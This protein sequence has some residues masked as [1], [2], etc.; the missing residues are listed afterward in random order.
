MA[1]EEKAT[2][3]DNRADAW[4][5]F[6]PIETLFFKLDVGYDYRNV[7]RYGYYRENT[8]ATSFDTSDDMMKQHLQNLRARLT[9]GTLDPSSPVDVRIGLGVES[10][11]DRYKY[12]QT[13]FDLDYA[14]GFRARA[15]GRLILDGAI[16]LIR[17]R[18]NLKGVKNP[19]GRFDFAYETRKDGL[20]LRLGAGFGFAESKPSPAGRD[21]M[22]IAFLPQLILE[23]ELAEGRLT[24]FVHLRGTL[25]DNS[26]GALTRRNPYLYSG[27]YAPHTLDYTARA[28]IKGTI[29][30]RLRYTV[31]GGYTM[32]KN[33]AF[34]ANAYSGV[35]APG[36]GAN[37]SFYNN[38]GN[39]FTV[40]TDDLN[41]FE[42]GADFE[43]DILGVLTWSGAL[44]CR[45]YSPDTF[46]EAWGMPAMTASM[47]LTYNHRD[48]LYLN[49]GIEYTGVRQ[50]Y[51]HVY[52][53]IVNELPGQ[54]D[55]T[56][57]LDYFINRQIGV[58]FQANNLLNQRLY[59]FNRYPGL[60]LNGVVGIELSF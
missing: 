60:G 59:E 52:E 33:A 23:K 51:S 5:D 21:S 1:V 36:N 53:G 42:A 47:G 45:S 49:A 27:Q 50:M 10:F 55:L 18:N 29:D 24:P 6:R 13:R 12:D 17:G 39:V 11:M 32:Q 14:F 44:N 35:D 8:P 48:R 56:F 57:G 41:F 30:S 54:T 38:K 26:Y 3:T 20:W 15:N 19:L 25:V 22:R 7:L 4:I 31:Y 37:Q 34:W 16:S 58:F 40:L 2:S 9:V 43:A 46:A 28:G